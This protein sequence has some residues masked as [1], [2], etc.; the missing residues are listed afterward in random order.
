MKIN[1]D[2]WLVDD[3]PDETNRIEIILTERPLLRTKDDLSL[4]KKN[5]TQWSSFVMPNDVIIKQ[6]GTKEEN[7]R[8]ISVHSIDKINLKELDSFCF[9]LSM[10]TRKHR[11]VNCQ[12]WSSMSLIIRIVLSWRFIDRHL[13]Q[14]I[15]FV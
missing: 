15:I 1:K 7:K 4:E 3:L 9:C 2:F 13:D 10:K 12:Y 5:E 14:K 8:V 6:C 11:K